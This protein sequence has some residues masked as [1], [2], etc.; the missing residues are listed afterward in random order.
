[1]QLNIYKDYTTLSRHTAME[2]IECVKNKPHATLCL[3][4]GDTPRL[5]YSILAEKAREEKLDFSRATFI[6]LD[7]W[8]DISPQNEGSCQFF[9]Q[10]QLFKPLGIPPGQMHLFDAQSPD[11]E[12]QCTIMD[13]IIS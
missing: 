12:Q 13:K 9:L 11:L 1:M 6:G 8:I 4:A 7:E 2:I 10:S 5:T 3:A